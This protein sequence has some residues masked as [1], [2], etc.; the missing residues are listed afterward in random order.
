MQNFTAN[1]VPFYF[2]GTGLLIVVSVALD[3]VQQI[4]GH[5]IAKQYDGITQTAGGHIRA[6]GELDAS[7]ENAP[8]A[9][10]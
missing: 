1:Q 3:T 8:T 7:S 2:G 4:E 9:Q 6:R 10:S 5:Y